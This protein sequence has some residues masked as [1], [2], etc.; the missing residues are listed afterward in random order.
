MQYRTISDRRSI[1]E[2]NNNMQHE[3]QSKTTNIFYSVISNN[4]W[5]QYYIIV[6]N[7]FKPL[8]CLPTNAGQFTS[9]DRTASETSSLLKLYITIRECSTA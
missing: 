9:F 3:V 4:R 1:A 2:K 8:G 5:I 6:A 7:S